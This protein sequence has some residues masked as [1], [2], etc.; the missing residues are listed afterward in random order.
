MLRLQQIQSLACPWT[1][2]HPGRP[3]PWVHRALAGEKHDQWRRVG[4]FGRHTRNMQQPGN[5]L[6]AQPPGQ[7]I[8]LD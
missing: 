5:G 4:R 2:Q 6:T 7:R 8:E 1:G 3:H